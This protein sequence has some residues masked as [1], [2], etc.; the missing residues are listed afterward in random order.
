[1]VDLGTLQGN[2]SGA[3]A[4]S[5]DGNT[6]VGFDRVPSGQPSKVPGGQL[7][8][9]FWN[10]LE[11][12]MHP[13]GWTGRAEATNHNGSIIVGEW[14]PL[15]GTFLPDGS[16]LPYGG[17]TWMYTAW[18]GRFEDL[19]AVRKTE[20]GPIE[21]LNEY[22]SQ[23]RGVSDDG[24]VVVGVSG[25]ST[26]ETAFIWTR[27]TGMVRVSDYLTA[28]GVTAHNG[29]TLTRTYYVSPD[30]KRIVG[31]AINPDSLVQSWIVT[32]R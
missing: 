26:Q 4:V 10:G 29:W 25:T 13:F 17:T 6:I 3:D 14:A 19:G 2:D 15:Q 7:G 16:F 18:D 30:G 23:P 9:I 32:L 11:R 24:S 5:G 12:L 31:N 28:N 22:V 8:V 1:M 20:L 21:A 27:A